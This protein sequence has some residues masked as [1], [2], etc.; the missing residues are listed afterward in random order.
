DA[1]LTF[2]IV[3]AGPTGVEMA[4]AIS[5]LAHW[6]LRRNFRAI[7]P[8]K[9]RIILVEGADRVL[10]PYPADLSAKAEQALARLGVEVWDGARVTDIQPRRVTIHRSGGETTIAAG[11][12]IWAARV[13]PS[14]PGQMIA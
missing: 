6:T 5:E 4:G 9:A 7:D 14:P 8:A 3:G 1:A 13:L 10:P 11:T 12:G 2:V